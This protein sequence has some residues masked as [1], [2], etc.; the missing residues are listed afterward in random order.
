M[1]LFKHKKVERTKAITSFN[2]PL[3]S[4]VSSLPT[5]TEGNLR[6]YNFIC[7]HLY[8]SKNFFFFFFGAGFSSYGAQAL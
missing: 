6:Y 7:K 2:N 3:Q 4:A 5:A 8:I 1:E